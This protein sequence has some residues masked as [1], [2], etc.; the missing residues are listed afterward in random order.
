MTPPGQGA[1]VFGFFGILTCALTWPIAVFLDQSFYTH[2]DYFS[3]LWNI[4]WV[5]KSMLEVRARGDSG[6]MAR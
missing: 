4:W 2:A 3:N 1:L 5:R 6:M